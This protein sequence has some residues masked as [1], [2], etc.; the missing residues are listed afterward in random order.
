M[1]NTPR[2]NIPE[3]G[4]T[5]NNKTITINN[6]I[7]ALEQAMNAALAVAVTGSGPASVTE[8]ELV[9]NALFRLQGSTS[10]NFNF[11]VPS[12]V[13]SVASTRLFAVRNETAHIATVKASTGAGASVTLAAGKQGFFYIDDEDVYLLALSG[14]TTAVYDFG[15]YYNGLPPNNAELMKMVA[16][17][18]FD[19]GANLANF[20]GHCA[21]NPTSSAAFTV[22]KN[23]STVATITVST[24]GVF[25]AS[26]SAFSMAAG[27]RLTIT[28]PSPQDATLANV[29]IMIAGTRAL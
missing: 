26:G 17:R 16:V 8:T 12:T 29:G 4:A 3:V 23:G 14:D 9:R 7:N 19:V 5:Q 13:N 1:A 22:A 18:A 11:N 15:F 10:G 6:A 25:S 27:D 20:R 28:A 24:G 21:V 2:L